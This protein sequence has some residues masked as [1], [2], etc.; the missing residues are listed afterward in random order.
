MDRS[1]TVNKGDPT[2]SITDAIDALLE[3]AAVL[4]TEAAEVINEII[5]ILQGLV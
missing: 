4:P 3:L 1:V 2:M 5:A